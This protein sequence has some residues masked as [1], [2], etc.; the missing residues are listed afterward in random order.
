MVLHGDGRCGKVNWSSTKTLLLVLLVAVNLLL[1]V[2]VYNH[3]KDNYFIGEDVAA[4][5]SE[6]LKK[7]NIKVDASLLDGFNEDGDVL[8]CSYEREDYVMLVASLLLG[9]EADGMYVL[10]HGVRAETFESETAVIG[11]D[12]SISFVSKELSDIDG[13]LGGAS[14]QSDSECKNE[15]KTLERVLALPSGSLDGAEC[16]KNGEYVFITVCQEENDIPLYGMDCVFGMHGEKIIYAKGKHLFCVP[17]EKQDTPILDRINIMFS[18][19]SRGAEGEV[20]SI[21]FCYTLYESSASKTMM[22]IPSYAVRY[23]DGT[24]HAVNAVSKDLYQN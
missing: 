1:G 12:M 21:T 23:A 22:L 8:I 15:R 5:A 20:V 19:K 7:S 2:Y 9:K 10:P 11:Y 4:E 6:I 24:V 14:P 18:E 17:E 16:K 3:F 13:L